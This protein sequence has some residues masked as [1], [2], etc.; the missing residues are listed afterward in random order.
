MSS[1]RTSINR[2][3]RKSLHFAWHLGGQ[4]EHR[5]SG[6]AVP[7]GGYISEEAVLIFPKNIHLCED[8]LLLSG[9]RLICAGMPPYLEAAGKIKIGAK[10][11]IR[12]GAILQSFGGSITVGKNC[13][14]NA[15]CLIQGPNVHI[16][17]NTLIAGHVCMFA[18]NHEF[19]DPTRLIRT[20]GVTAKGIQIGSDVWIGSGVKILD[21][22][23]VGDGAVI[24]AG[25]V[26]N[27]N[28]AAGAIVAGVPGRTIGERGNNK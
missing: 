24:A 16:G 2:V 11:I 19:S 9:A 17:D 3:Y 22:V 21:G 4:K 23:S 26:V 20:Q 6:H 7:T 28:I 18:S 12:E 5:P 14:V 13:T 15:Y 1:F 8:V 10:S 27:R 25:T